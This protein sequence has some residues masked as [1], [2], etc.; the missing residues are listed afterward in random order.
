M[1]SVRDHVVSNMKSGEA[2]EIVLER[3]VNVCSYRV[4]AHGAGKEY[5]PVSCYYLLIFER[6][7][8]GEGIR[9]GDPKL[10]LDFDLR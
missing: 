8:G 1:W 4:N 6:A 2:N 7:Q 10:Y 5:D 3:A 9:S